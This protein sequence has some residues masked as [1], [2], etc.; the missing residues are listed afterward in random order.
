MTKIYDVLVIGGGGAAARAALEACRSGADVLMATKGVFGVSGATAYPVSEQA[1]FSA[2]D[3]VIDPEDSPEVHYNDIIEAGLGMTDPKLA[4]ILAEE[5]ISALKDLENWGVQF[6]KTNGE[7]YERVACFASKPR[8]H[9]IKGHGVPIIRALKSQIEKARIMIRE[10]TFI[11]SL[12]IT[13]E[14]TC[15]GACGLDEKSNFMVFPAKSTIIA[16]GGIGR[17]F[18]LNL[19]PPDITGDGY[20]MAYRAGAELVNMEFAQMGFGVFAPFCLLLRMIWWLHPEIYN[21]NGEKFLEGSIPDGVAL[22]QCMDKKGDHYPFTARDNGKYIDIEIMSEIRRGQGTQNNGVWLDLSRK[23]LDFGETTLLGLRLTNEWFL[24]HGTDITK[25]PIEIAPFFH[26]SNGG[27]K[28]D[29]KASSSIIE[30]LFAAGEA[31]GGPHGADRLGGNMLAACQVFG[32]RAGKYA[33]QKAKRTGHILINNALIDKE[34]QRIEHLR[35]LHGKTRPSEIKKTLQKIMWRNLLIVRNA[36][37]LMQTIAKI[38]ELREQLESDAY[39]QN[40]TDLIK[41]LELQN[42]LEVGEIIVKTALM[43]KE[44]RGSHYRGD[45]PNVDKTLSSPI[46]TKK[47]GEKIYQYLLASSAFR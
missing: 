25:Q 29:E 20:A 10:S 2:A 34:K 19:N 42:M 11:T 44:S 46:I 37:E 1:G 28:I 8:S 24:S 7:Y 26:A 3:G 23:D 43:R 45:F 4:Q 39:I 15:M 14:G 41:S 36:G 27:I 17:L 5:V 33:A 21:K 30:G 16:T 31:A 9:V 13:K 22:E 35:Y 38:Q 32:K 47:R 6:E 40:S 12:L 18:R